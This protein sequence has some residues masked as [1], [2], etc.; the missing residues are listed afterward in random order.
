MTPQTVAVLGAS[1]KPDRYSN[2]A[3][4]QLAAAGHRVVPVHPSL[5]KIDGHDVAPSL[6]DVPKPVDTLTIYVGPDRLTPL[7]PDVVALRPSRVI[8]NPG[9]ECPEAERALTD[10]GIPWLHACTLVMLRTGQF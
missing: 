7:V 10:A 9:T 1:D 2:M 8:F 5:R 3:L 6:R 4:R